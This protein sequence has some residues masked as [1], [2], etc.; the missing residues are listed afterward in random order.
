M[1]AS[2]RRPEWGV[3]LKVRVD[4]GPE[5]TDQ[6][7]ADLIAALPGPDKRL[8]GRGRDFTTWAW[9]EGSDAPESIRVAGGMLRAAAE[10]QGIGPLR[11]VRA[12]AASVEGRNS[13]FQGV[14]ARLKRPNTWTIYFRVAG[15]PGGRPAGAGT[16]DEIRKALDRPDSSVSLGGDREKFLLD[17]GRGVVIRF[18]VE[19]LGLPDA[20]RSARRE[21][22]QVLSAVRLGDWSIVRMQAATAEARHGDTFPGVDKRPPGNTEET[23]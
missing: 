4:D 20:I 17:T 15:P 1:T 10:R 21:V 9:Y 11:I 3:L 14:A 23:R 19:G 5:P 22:L 8:T 16:V 12:H 2:S 6:A 18:W 7:L 13:P